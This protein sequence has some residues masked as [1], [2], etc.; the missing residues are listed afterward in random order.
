MRQ[1]LADLKPKLSQPEEPVKQPVIGVLLNVREEGEIQLLV[2]YLVSNAS[3]RPKYDLRVSS[4]EC[5]MEVRRE[6][7]LAAW[8]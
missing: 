2:S 5:T 3:W 8:I 7:S 4:K 1:R 6:A